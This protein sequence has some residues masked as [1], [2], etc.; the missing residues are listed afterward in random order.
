MEPTHGTAGA[1]SSLRNKRG[2]RTW[3]PCWANPGTTWLN[4][5]RKQGRKGQDSRASRSRATRARCQQRKLREELTGRGR[6]TLH[7][8]VGESGEM[9]RLR[10]LVGWQVTLVLAIAIFFQFLASMY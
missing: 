5:V 7:E 3:R 4:G 9:S 10:L 2:R 8:T 1:A 6:Q